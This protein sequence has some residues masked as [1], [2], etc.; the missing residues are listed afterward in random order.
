MSNQPPHNQVWIHPDGTWSSMRRDGSFNFIYAVPAVLKG[1]DT[2]RV[3]SGR[4]TADPK[5][6]RTA[7]EIF[8]SVPGEWKP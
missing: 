7:W 3:L 2:P 8:P 6:K 1:K 5:D 4:E